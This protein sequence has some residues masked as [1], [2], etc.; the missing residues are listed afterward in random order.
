M[1]PVFLVL[2]LL[3]AWLIEWVIDRLW[4]YDAPKTVT[5][6]VSRL[7]GMLD[8]MSSTELAA[9]FDDVM[10]R[11]SGE[12]KRRATKRAFLIGTILAFAFN[13]DSIEIAKTLW[14]EPTLR[15]VI[16]A[17]ANNSEVQASLEQVRQ[18]DIPV[19][20]STNYPTDGWGWLIKVFGL[21]IS[22]FAAA[23]GAPFWF[24]ILKKLI[25]LRSSGPTPKSERNDNASASSV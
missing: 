15:Q 18:L 6:D 23:Q 24:D 8:K 17:Q 19:G 20:W 5:T 21:L 12:Y 22:G 13:V 7:K 9:W 16:V 14:R 11:S 3:L 10:D 4:W 25:N 2:G 1:N